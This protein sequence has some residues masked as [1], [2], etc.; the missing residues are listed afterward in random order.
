MADLEDNGQ[1]RPKFKSARWYLNNLRW[2]NSTALGPLRPLVNGWQ[3][4]FKQ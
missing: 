2:A 1:G 4:F 3:D